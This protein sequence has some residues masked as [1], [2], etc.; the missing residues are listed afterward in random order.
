MDSDKWI[1]H[2]TTNQANQTQEVQEDNHRGSNDRSDT[3]CGD[4][5]SEGERDCVLTSPPALDVKYCDIEGM[6]TLS[7]DQLPY[8][9][10]GTERGA[11]DKPNLTCSWTAGISESAHSVLLWLEN[12]L[13]F[14]VFILSC[15][16]IQMFYFCL[17]VTPKAHF[18]DK[19]PKFTEFKAGLLYLSC[20]AGAFLS[21]AC[22]D[23]IPP[24][25]YKYLC[26][27]F[28]SLLLS[29]TSRIADMPHSF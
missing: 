17:N 9:M 29:A 8:D 22:T 13:F 21:M 14:S 27:L 26:T 11:M 23:H 19:L 28:F 2:L 12:L 7:E 4:E 10:S 3:P 16:C 5:D 15:D 25:S 24:T 6:D 1:D 18:F 20:V